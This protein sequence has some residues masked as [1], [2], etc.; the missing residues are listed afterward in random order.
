MDTSNGSKKKELR[1][2]L[3]LTVVL[4]PVI[5]VAIVGGYGFSVWISQL[6]IG[7]PGS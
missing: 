7:P 2:F 1:A 6:L 4:A 3:L 5:A